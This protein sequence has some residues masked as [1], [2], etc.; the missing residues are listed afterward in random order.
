MYFHLLSDMITYT[1]IKQNFKGAA[2]VL[3]QIIHRK[4]GVLSNNTPE[5]TCN[6]CIET[7]VYLQLSDFKLL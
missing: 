2:Y 1:T 5:I 6:E 4:S 7:K 3:L